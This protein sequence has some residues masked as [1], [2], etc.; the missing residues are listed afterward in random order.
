MEITIESSGST[1]GDETIQIIS[2]TNSLP[3][4][5]IPYPDSLDRNRALNRQFRVLERRLTRLEDTQLTGQEVNL[6]IDGVYAEIDGLEDQIDRRFDR[7]EA[8]F[9]RLEMRIEQ[10]FHE[11]NRKLDRS[12]A[13]SPDNT[14]SLGGD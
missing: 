2:T 10:Q 7:L 6:S 14:R 1:I 12:I 3:C 11:L 8:R 5:T 4:M 9:D 13:S